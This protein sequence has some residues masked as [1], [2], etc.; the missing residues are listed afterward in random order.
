M[1]LVS[2]S[3]E[4]LVL[5]VSFCLFLKAKATWTDSPGPA[6]RGHSCTNSCP[7]TACGVGEIWS[8]GRIQWGSVSLSTMPPSV[9]RTSC[10]PRQQR[11]DHET[12]IKRDY[13]VVGKF[14]PCV[15]IR[16]PRG[17]ALEEKGEGLSLSPGTFRLKRQSKEVRGP[18]SRWSCEAVGLTV[19]QEIFC[20]VASVAPV[21]VTVIHIFLLRSGCFHFS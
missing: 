15:C 10:Y 17:S 11:R 2:T 16:S 5:R 1:R 13:Y 4:S 19:R 21:F 7:P 20:R 18:P 8:T 6:S 9:F 3:R 14:V 12:Q